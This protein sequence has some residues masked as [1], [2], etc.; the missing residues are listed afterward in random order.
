[1]Y[2][3]QNSKCKWILNLQ[4]QMCVLHACVR[5]ALPMHVCVCVSVVLRVQ[6]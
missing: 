2:F 6:T 1:M 4:L 3:Q 5:A